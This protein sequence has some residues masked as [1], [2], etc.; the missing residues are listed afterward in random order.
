MFRACMERS[1]ASSVAFSSSMLG[2]RERA[3][4]ATTALE[5]RTGE[6]A[7][8]LIACAASDAERSFSMPLAIAATAATYTSEVRRSR[9][10]HPSMPVQYATSD[11]VYASVP[12]WR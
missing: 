1:R 10:R 12:N 9:A 2:G 7:T 11:M 6:V 4:P 5:A 8:A 3:R